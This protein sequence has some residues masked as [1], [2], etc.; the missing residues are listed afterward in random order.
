MPTWSLHSGSPTGPYLCLSYHCSCCSHRHR[1][2]QDIPSCL[3]GVGAL[4]GT[5]AGGIWVPVPSLHQCG[6]SSLQEEGQG[7]GEGSEKG[8]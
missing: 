6:L 4:Q 7:P 1:N 5:L 8:L 2:G 3:I